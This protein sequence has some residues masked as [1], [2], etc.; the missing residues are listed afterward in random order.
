MALSI[1]R[2]LY[3]NGY[4]VLWL[5]SLMAAILSPVMAAL[6]AFPCCIAGLVFAAF[7]A[8]LREFQTVSHSNPPGA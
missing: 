1:K 8:S 2:G 5:L 4:L 6:S 3:V 7:P